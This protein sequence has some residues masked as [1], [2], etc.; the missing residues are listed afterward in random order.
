MVGP[1][2][3][4]R[5]LAGERCD[6]HGMVAIGE[7]RIPRRRKAAVDADAVL[8]LEADRLVGRAAGRRGRIRAGR[9]P[10]LVARY[11]R[12]QSRLQIR[13]GVRPR[14]PVV[15]ARGRPLDVVG[16]RHIRRVGRHLGGR[17]R[18]VAERVGGSHAVVIRD[19][20]D[21]PGI[22]EHG[23]GVIRRDAVGRRRGEAHRRAAVHVVPGQRGGRAGGP[24]QIDLRGA[25]RRR[26]HTGRRWQEIDVKHF[27]GDAERAGHRRRVE[28]EVTCVNTRAAGGTRV[29]DQR[30]ALAGGQARALN[31]HEHAG[32]G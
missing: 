9:H 16:V 32:A 24:C 20:V 30:V 11:R 4:A 23:T 27:A 26:R 21:Q 17:R 2:T 12:G 18:F 1:P 22:R 8:E 7:P 10:D 28:R 19:V 15:R 25:D 5:K 31:L 13:K 29:I 6:V 3:S 14:P